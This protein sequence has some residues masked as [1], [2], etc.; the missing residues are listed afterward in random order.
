MQNSIIVSASL[1]GSVYLFS[2]SLELIN[3]SFLVKK[4]IPY[5]LLVLNC[6]ALGISAS[7]YI[8]LNFHYLNSI[9]DK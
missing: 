3:Q 5:S 8:L 7:T 4:I 6:L 9:T 2:K 1:F